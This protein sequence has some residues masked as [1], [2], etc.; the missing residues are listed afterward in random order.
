MFLLTDP[1]ST[2]LLLGD[3]LSYSGKHEFVIKEHV[4]HQDL[5]AQTWDA[6]NLVQDTLSSLRP[7]H[8]W[9]YFRHVFFSEIIKIG[10]PFGF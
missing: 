6:D 7:T 8:I 1:L 5:V 3:V 10:N 2:Y 4:G 9:A